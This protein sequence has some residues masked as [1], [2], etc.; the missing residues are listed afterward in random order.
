M[1]RVN[2]RCTCGFFF[3]VPD[4]QLSQGV[5]CPSCLRRVAIDQPDPTI[6][7]AP[8]K[9]DVKRAAPT[10]ISF[11]RTTM[12]L[13]GGGLLVVAIGVVYFLSGGDENRRNDRNRLDAGHA[14]L[15]EGDRRVKRNPLGNPGTPPPSR[16]ETPVVVTPPSNRTSPAPQAG[17][18]PPGPGSAAQAAS[19]SQTPPTSSTANT[20]LVPDLLAR[21]RE[22]LALPPWYR[23][24]L[25]P[26]ALDRARVEGVVSVGRGTPEDIAFLETLLASPKV[27][28]VMDERVSIRDSLERLGK[29]AFESLPVDRV[30]MADNRILN[31]RIVEDGTETVRFERKLGKGVGGVMNLKR[32]DIRELQKGR[33]SGGEF[34]SKWDLATKGAL[35]DQLAL[36]GWCRENT[37]LAQAQ[38]TA[39]LVLTT[40]P[41]NAAARAEAGLP[42]NPVQSAIELAAQGGGITYQGRTWAPKELK[43]R[44]LK[45]GFALINGEW[46]SRKERMISVGSL[47]RYERE[48][49]KPVQI[50]STSAPINHETEIVYKTVQD[51]GTNQFKGVQELKYLRRFYSPTLLVTTTVQKSVVST[52]KDVETHTDRIDPPAGKAITGEV[53]IT[54]PVGAPLIEGSVITT[55]ETKQGGTITVYQI[56]RGERIKLYTCKAKEEE[57]HPLADS[58][59]GQTQVELVAVIATQAA[60]TSKTERH[61]ICGLKMDQKARTVIQKGV[62]LVHDR[63]IPEYRAILFPSH[64]NTYE[65][66]RLKA[67][68]GEPAPVLNRLFAD[69]GVADILKQ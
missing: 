63:Q 10:T 39:F 19:G 23:D 4:T 15:G 36:L 9:D 2:L 58:I 18:P 45:D 68:L 47:F 31:G 59:R 61:D 24:L 64:S 28:A 48:A 51:V 43:D 14:E 49:D 55:A 44:L 37:L 29:E 38:M 25:L 8:R 17:S 60:Y 3:S 34:R 5:K 1:A 50:T 57:S 40:E 21:L 56:N 30:V 13:V 33:G 26:G 35:A 32:A 11:S 52:F 27:R 66:F 46:F 67:V 12:A 69:A 41:G 7:S 16:P 54:V 22:L 42:S 62:E 65:V 6:P 20:P 53:F